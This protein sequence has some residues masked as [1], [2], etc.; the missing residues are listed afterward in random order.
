MARRKSE[1]QQGVAERKPN[2]GAATGHETELW[3]MADALPGS[4]DAGGEDDR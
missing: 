3:A 1:R 4:M 2:E